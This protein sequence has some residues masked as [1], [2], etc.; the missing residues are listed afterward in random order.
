[1]S[2]FDSKS[3]ELNLQRGDQVMVYMPIEK[4]GKA[5]KVARPYYGPYRVLKVT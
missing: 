2:Q 4:Q 3:Q 5:R 1:M